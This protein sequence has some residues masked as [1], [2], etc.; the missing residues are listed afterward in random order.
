MTW[1]VTTLTFSLETK[2]YRCPI[3]DLRILEVYRE[4]YGLVRTGFLSSH[5]SFVAF[6]F[7]YSPS[8]LR[9]NF[10]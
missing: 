4:G 5:I 1:F 10:S 9:L 3:Y 7:F 6:S 2:H 8:G